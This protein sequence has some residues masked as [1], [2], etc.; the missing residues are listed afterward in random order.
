MKLW[1]SQSLTCLEVLVKCSLT[2]LEEYIEKR[3]REKFKGC[4]KTGRG[5]GGKDPGRGNEVGRELRGDLGR[6]G[7]HGEERKELERE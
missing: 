6:V 7:G 3:G 2:I 1:F 5:V 4:G